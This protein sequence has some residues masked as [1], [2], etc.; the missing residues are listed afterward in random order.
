MAATNLPG[1][2]LGAEGARRVS[3]MDGASQRCPDAPESPIAATG[4]WPPRR[5][6]RASASVQG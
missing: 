3:A 2:N 4:G 5:S 1:A 6:Y